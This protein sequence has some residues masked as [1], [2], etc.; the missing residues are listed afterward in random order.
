MTRTI[1]WLER[2]IA[3]PT[4][5]AQSNL[6]LIAEIEAA[7]IQAGAV[8]ER[9]PDA[10]G[11]KAALL[12]RFGPDLPGGLLLS[13]HVDVVPVAGQ[14]WTVPPFEMTRRNSRLYGRGSTDMKGFVASVM[15][16]AE[17]IDSSNLKKPLWI[18][19]SYDEEIGC[20]GVRPMLDEMQARR[21]RPNLIIVGEPTSMQLGLGHKGKMAFHGTL[22]GVPRH[23]AEAPMALN[24]L[25]L[26]ADFING[27]RDWQDV[28]EKNGTH[29]EGYSVPYATVHVGK[30]TGGT[31]VNLVPDRAELF[32]ECRL[33]AADNPDSFRQHIFEIA[34]RVV[35]NHKARFEQAAIDMDETGSYPGLATSFDN[36]AVQALRALMP[37]ETPQCRV[38][39][40]TEGGLFANALA[41]PVVICGPGNMEQGHCPDEFISEEQLAACDRL[42]PAVVERF[43]RNG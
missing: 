15:A 39:F 41:S 40:G 13:A 28:I 16:M 2:L 5:S 38:S 7:L 35:V 24:A 14:N 33:L 43:C 11:Q 42:L 10:T 27:L 22:H 26:A 1:N 9:F 34:D 3:H 20:V 4:V 29:E 17:T 18:A 8:C 36:P 21:I 25:H 37:V 30:L 6:P 19:I 12:A 23:S 31:A 32:M